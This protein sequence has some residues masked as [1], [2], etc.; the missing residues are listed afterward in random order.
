[1][2]LKSIFLIW[3]FVPVALFG[4][5][6]RISETDVQKEALFLDA[7]Q[8]RILENYDEAIDA[9]R[10]IESTDPSNDVVQFE[11]AKLYWV[12][13]QDQ[14]AILFAKKA[15]GNKP[16]RNV[17]K[18][19]LIDIYSDLKDYGALNELLSEFIDEGNYDESYYMQLVNSYVSSG[20][21]KN[22]LKVLD[23]LEDRI[24]YRKSI[25]QKRA[26]IYS[27]E[28]NE[29]K[30]VRELKKL[31]ET[32]PEDTSLLLRVATLYQS[33]RQDDEA[34]E[35][36][37]RI[38]EID[39][40][41]S[42]ANSRMATWNKRAKSENEFIVSLRKM[43]D[44]ENIPLDDKIKELIPMVPKLESGSKMT[45]EMIS[46][47]D[48]LDKMYPDNPKVS[49]L[50]GDVYFNSGQLEKAIPFYR[51][52]LELNKSV[53][54]VWKN[55]MLA[56]DNTF[57]FTGLNETAEEALNYFPNQA[58]CYYYAGKSNIEL[59]RLE[60]GIDW[61]REGLFM[62]GDNLRLQAE[63]HLMMSQYHLLKK[64][65]DQAVREFNKADPIILGPRH[66]FYFE[67]KGDLEYAGGDLQ[68]AVQSWQ[69]SLTNG[70]R[71]LRID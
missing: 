69:Q 48:R 62:V 23:D 5:T 9:F 59:N 34:Y 30:L 70:G 54:L 25:G 15:I 51:K 27:R 31:A 46:L 41:H 6:D 1:M 55:L 14:D 2:R 45:I 57:D 63:F 43:M 29:R 42:A 19:F 53:F 12:K 32:F 44:N 7:L 16:E 40:D 11:L 38:L 68:K 67:I 39:P 18:E 50:Y 26:G 3:L 65:V 64:E 17:Y 8:M 61:L 71:K 37:Q 20:D 66:S 49:A 22:A 13:R 21:H 28:R 52:T 35:L 4:Q 56:Q 10:A 33:V 36:Y 24:G 58:V 47:M 60:P